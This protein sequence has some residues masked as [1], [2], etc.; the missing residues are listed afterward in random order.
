M[1]HLHPKLNSKEI[2]DNLYGETSLII[3]FVQVAIPTF[4]NLVRRQWFIHTLTYT[5]KQ[6]LSI[7]MF[8]TKVNK[9]LKNEDG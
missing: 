1:N 2:I 5:I 9:S 6:E 3:C 7:T 4:K 8:W